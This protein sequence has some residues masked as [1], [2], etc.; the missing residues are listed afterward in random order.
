MPG[1]FPIPHRGLV[2]LTWITTRAWRTCRDGHSRRMHNLQF[3]YLVKGSLWAWSRFCG[4]ASQETFRYVLE[5]RVF[6]W[7]LIYPHP[8]GLL[9]GYFVNCIICIMASVPVAWFINHHLKNVDTKPTVTHLPF[10]LLVVFAFCQ[11]CPNS[12]NNSCGNCYLGTHEL[13]WSGLISML[14]TVYSWLI[15]RELVQR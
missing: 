4:N 13:E 14:L 15:V 11:W 2:I 5:S 6:W 8:S 1:T 10:V 9:N 7:A 12:L 3:T